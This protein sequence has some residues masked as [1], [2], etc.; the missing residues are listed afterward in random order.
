MSVP[1]VQLG[2][3][4]IVA[5]PVCGEEF[6]TPALSGAGR[7]YSPLCYVYHCAHCPCAAAIREAAGLPPLRHCAAERIRQEFAD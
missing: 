1:R 5:C 2:D 6:D 3:L 4:A 7:R